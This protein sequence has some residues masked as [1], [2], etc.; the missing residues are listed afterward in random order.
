M[1]DYQLTDEDLQTFKKAFAD[2]DPGVAFG[3][4]R[5]QRALRWGYNR[6]ISFLNAAAD[7]GVLERDA[8]EYLFRLKSNQ[9]QNT[10]DS[11][12]NDIQV[13]AE[14]SLLGETLKVI[15][16]KGDFPPSEL[17]P[18]VIAKVTG[19]LE[20]GFLK[21]PWGVLWVVNDSDSEFSSLTEIE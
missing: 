13:G 18:E 7:A 5:I 17:F 8:T 4:S 3:A 21:S 2:L 16:L 10:A 11:L 20:P 6:A 12:V 15:E 1:P 9:V 14:I 19:S